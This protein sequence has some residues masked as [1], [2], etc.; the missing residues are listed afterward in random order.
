MEITDLP[1]EGYERVVKADDPDS[2]LRAIVAVHDTTLGPALG[3]MRMWAYESEDAAL[4]DVLRLARGMTFKSAIAHTGLGGG[5][6]VII[7]DPKTLKS[8][9]LFL[10]M[11]RFIDS[12]EG[13][14]ITAEDVSINVP[15]LQIVRRATRFVTGL[16]REDGGSGNPSPYTAYGVFLGIRAALAWKF[17]TDR[18]KGRRIAVQGVGAVGSALCR[19]LRKAGAEVLVADPKQERIDT[20]V[21]EIGV[22]PATGDEILEAKADLFAPCALGAVVND[23]TIDRFGA[24]I[25]AGAANNCLHEPRHGRELEARG[26]LY[27]PDYVINAGGIINVSVE[28]A[29]GGYD[30][31]IALKRIERIPQA[32]TEVWT[33]S[34]EQHIPSSDAADRL[35]ENILAEA[36]QARASG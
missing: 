4:T 22:V 26:I 11:G 13:L 10:A 3:G 25:I 16:S 31:D 1:V 6:S 14:Y 18:L 12:L 19:R 20:L 17:G 29:D 2:G 23:R 9:P 8:E 15:D 21:E 33:I 24:G 28:F 30:Q 32:L 35:A 27:A 36:R 5:K 34:R 7:G